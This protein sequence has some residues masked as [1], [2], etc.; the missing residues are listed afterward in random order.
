MYTSFRFGRLTERQS[1]DVGQIAN[2][3]SSG[4][5]Y[6]NEILILI[7]IRVK[8]QQQTKT[9]QKVEGIRVDQ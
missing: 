5:F 8:T 9:Q 2:V 1:K 3:I 4:Y 7:L 6:F